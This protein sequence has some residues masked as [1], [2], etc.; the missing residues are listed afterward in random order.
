MTASRVV[1][2]TLEQAITIGV[3]FAGMSHGDTS[4]LVDL[5]A[6]PPLG[7]FYYRTVD[8]TPYAGAPPLLQRRANPVGGGDWQSR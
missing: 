2:V 6:V 7:T 8:Q 1:A 3:D 5:T 4:Q